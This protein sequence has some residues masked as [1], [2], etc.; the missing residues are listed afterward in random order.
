MEFEIN[1]LSKWWFGSKDEWENKVKQLTSNRDL[2][3]PE[4]PVIAYE[5]A[6]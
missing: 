2:V 6:C 5:L 3:E 4:E 1:I